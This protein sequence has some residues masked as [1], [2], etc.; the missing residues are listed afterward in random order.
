M[1]PRRA[2]SRV[3]IPSAPNVQECVNVLGEDKEVIEIE[4]RKENAADT[5]QP[6]EQPQDHG[7]AVLE[8][9]NEAAPEQ[10]HQRNGKDIVMM[11]TPII[12]KSRS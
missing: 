7:E 10:G 8:T 2:I 5:E 6:Q 12:I 4:F 11:V 1:P 9:Q 3:Q